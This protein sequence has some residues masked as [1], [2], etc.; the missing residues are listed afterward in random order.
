MAGRNPKGFGAFLKA[1]MCTQDTGLA[2]SFQ[3]RDGWAPEGPC[4][5]AANPDGKHGSDNG[6]AISVP[7]RS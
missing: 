4:D 2:L 3:E 7:E 6:R 5:L 1:G